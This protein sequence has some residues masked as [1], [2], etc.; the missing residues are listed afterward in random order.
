MLAKFGVD[1]CSGVSPIDETNVWWKH[2]VICGSGSGSGTG[3][4]S[5]FKKWLLDIPKNMYAK[6]DVDWCSG[7]SPIHETK[8][9]QKDGLDYIIFKMAAMAAIL[10]FPKWSKSVVVGPKHVHA[11]FC[12]DWS[13]GVPSIEET[14]VWLTESRT[15]GRTDGR[16]DG[17]RAFH[18]P[19]FFQCGG[20]LTAGYVSRI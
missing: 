11:K 19:P 5:N 12:V 7:V 15:D 13:S 18:S 4:C 14:K 17:R 16:K 3:L 6:F 2:D 20:Q 10:D 8:V 1:W 9:W